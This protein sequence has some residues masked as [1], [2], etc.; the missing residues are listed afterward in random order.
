ML[1]YILNLA[2][3]GG[4]GTITKPTADTGSY[5]L[6]APA[7]VNTSNYQQYLSEELQ[8]I[9]SALN[10]ISA[11]HIDVSYSLPTKYIEG[12]IR[13]ADGAG[14]NPGSG[15]GFYVYR[16]SAWQYLG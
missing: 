9:S 4:S 15:K 5:A 1:L 6:Y 7:P 8:K 12:D 13:L 16:N 3:G 14:W 10:L 11:G 2:A